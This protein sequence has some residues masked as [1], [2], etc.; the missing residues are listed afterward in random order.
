[1]TGWWSPPLRLGMPN[2]TPEPIDTVQASPAVMQPG[3]A[4]LAALLADDRSGTRTV[5]T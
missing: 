2:A 3:D 1:M 4:T 5:V